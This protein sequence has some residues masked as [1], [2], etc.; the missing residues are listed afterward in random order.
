MDYT[1]TTAG[2][3]AGERTTMRGTNGSSKRHRQ[4]LAAL[5][6][7]RRCD[8]NDRCFWRGHN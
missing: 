7:L 8:L 6:W 4:Q 1:E 5:F 3:S 2:I